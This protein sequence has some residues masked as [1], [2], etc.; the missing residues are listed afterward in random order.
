DSWLSTAVAVET[1]GWPSGLEIAHGTQWPEARDIVKDYV[2]LGRG[3]TFDDAYSSL[4]EYEPIWKRIDRGIARFRGPATA[5]AS[6][7]T[8]PYVIANDSNESVSVRNFHEQNLRFGNNAIAQNAANG[9]AG[10][11]DRLDSILV[12]LWIRQGDHDL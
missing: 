9:S 7:A 8:T 4:R 2:R 3:L 11:L 5:A 1:K 6:N 10:A 12:P